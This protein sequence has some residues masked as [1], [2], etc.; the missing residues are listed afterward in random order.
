MGK[1]QEEI[2]SK[3]KAAFKGSIQTFAAIVLSVDETTMT[4]D[5]EPI[6]QSP[7]NEV[8]LKAAIDEVTDGIVEFPKVDSSVL[9][10]LIGNDENE[11]VLLKCSEV[12]KVVFFGGENGGL[13]N[14][15]TLI[16]E[17]DKT[18]EMVGAITQIL[19]GSPITEAGNGAP[20]ALQL[21]LS[22]A[23]AGKNLGDFTT[24]EDTKV[25]H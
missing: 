24:M 6:G 7:I 18:N 9:I 14:I 12:D 19:S 13:I 25:T 10:G 17:L 22:T 11:A 16:E 15:Q 4:V 8:R 21:A 5:V 1:K 3:M 20:S 2:R 23:I